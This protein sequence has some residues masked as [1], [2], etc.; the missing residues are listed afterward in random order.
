M[1]ARLTRPR[2]EGQSIPLIA[3][4]IVVLF[5]MVG[6]SVDVGNTYAQQRNTVRGTNA[7]ALA[8]MTALISNGTDQSIG[9]VIQQSLASNQISGVYD[10]GN[11]QASGNQR[12]IR[13]HYMDAKGNFL[14]ACNI[15]SCGTVPTGTTYIEVDVNGTVDTYFAKVVQRP[16]LPV[17]AQAFAGRCTPVQGVYPIGIQSSNLDSTGTK[18]APANPPTS[19]D[20]SFT[21]KNSSYPGG[22]SGKRI[23]MQDNGSGPGQFS[24]LKWSAANNAGN[25]TELVTMLQGDGSLATGFDEGIYN[26][27]TGVFTWPDSN[28]T[29]PTVGGKVVY[30]IKPHEMN[31]GDFVYGNGGVSWN[32]S[33]DS[34]LK[35]HIDHQTIMILPIV[36]TYVKK[37]GDTVFPVQGLAA[38]YLTGISEYGTGGPSGKYLKAN[39]A[40]GFFD[41]AY[42]GPA[43]SVACLSTPAVVS[44]TIGITGA[45]YVKPAWGLVQQ[46][47]PIS[48][49]IIMDVSGSMSWNFKGQGSKNGTIKFEADTTGT[50]TTQQCEATAANPTPV[51]CGGGYDDPW[52]KVSERRIYVLKQALAGPGGFIENLKINDTMRIIA[53][54]SNGVESASPWTGDQATLKTTV[55]DAGDY[56]TDSY[57]TSGGTNGPKAINTAAKILAN[58]PPPPASNGMAYKPVVIYLTDGVANIF[59]N[60]SQTTNYASDVCPQYGGDSRALNDVWCQYDKDGYPANSHGRRPISEMIYQAGLMK[61]ANPS[62]QFFTVGIANVNPLGLDQVATSPKY[63]YLATDASL[64]SKVLDSIYD[65]V[66]GP[67]AQTSAGGYLGSIDAAHTAA[68]P[69]MPV[70]PANVYGYVYLFDSSFNAVPVPWTMGGTDPRGAATNSIPITTDGFGNLT[71]TVPAAN[72]LPAGQYHQRAYVNY[73]AAN[74]APTAGGDGISRQYSQLDVNA[75]HPQYTDFVLTPSELLGSTKVLDNIKL[76]IDDAVNLCK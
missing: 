28:S 36:N 22:L 19:S 3:L 67:C 68:S 31:T 40:N 25:A 16:T 64:V 60:A 72:G 50:T 34:A 23:F 12:I 1:Y 51:A 2:N 57:R 6:V 26:S 18:F 53:F 48:Y 59:N 13:A 5:A 65:A 62:M 52:W 56:G 15:G 14:L 71:Y 7:A 32:T 46:Q 58:S 38:F 76:S 39:G 41:L 9:Q 44:N 33:V 74:A 29:P 54:S 11:V 45:V 75:L 17:G 42:I 61:T 47:Q 10:N 4:L 24:W 37:G 63:L 73:K 49:Q 43:N 20:Y 70:L 69:P 66:V 35:Y 55:M 27:S 30:P 21:F 8:G